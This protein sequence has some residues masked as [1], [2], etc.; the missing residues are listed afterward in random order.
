MKDLHIHT[1]YSDGEYDEY[2][3]LNKIKEAKVTEFAICDHDTLEGSIKIHNLLKNKT[4]NLKF[5]SGVE[6]S[7]IVHNFKNKNIDVHL[8]VRDFDYNDPIILNFI[9]EISYLRSL[10]IERMVKLV[11]EIYNF[12]ISQKDIDE[13]LKQT[14]SFGKPHIYQILSKYNNYDR[15][16]FYK[17]MNKLKSD[18]LKLDAIKVIQTINKTKGNVTLAHPIE[19]MEEYNFTYQDIEKLVNYLK[20]FG[21]HGLETMHSKHTQE[22]YEQFAKIANKFKLNQ[23]QGSDYHGPTVKPHVKLG[24]CKKNK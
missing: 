3:I 24:I 19:I 1:K 8:L 6:L 16:Q 12:N 20:E 13:I 23:T 10:K 17:N 22:N 18:D 15:E 14:N 2:E 21:L 9:H 4:N 7:C 11:K 5:H